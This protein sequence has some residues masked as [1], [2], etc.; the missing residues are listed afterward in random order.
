MGGAQE[1]LVGGAAE[2][3]VQRLKVHGIP[4]DSCRE[5]RESLLSIQK[6][7]NVEKLHSTL[8]LLVKLSLSMKTR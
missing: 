4:M 1:T 7:V 6:E 8:K 5:W 3:K 2:V